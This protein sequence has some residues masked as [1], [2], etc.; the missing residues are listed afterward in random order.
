MIHDL[1]LNN[2]S[3]GI[4]S[5]TPILFQMEI[6]P[7]MTVKRIQE[8]VAD[9]YGLTPD[10][11][12]SKSQHFAYAHPRQLAMYLCREMLGRSRADIGRRFGGRDHTTVI[13]ALKRVRDRLT[14]N[15]NLVEDVAAIKR[16][17][18]A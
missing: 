1:S 13:H 9:Y 14:T 16:R 12:T 7:R 3:L 5:A 4:R 2:Y 11:M 17:L 18:R 6:R 8:V 15:E 10:K